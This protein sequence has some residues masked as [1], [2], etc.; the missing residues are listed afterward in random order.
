MD[1][2]GYI[3]IHLKDLKIRPYP[4]NDRQPEA[5]WGCQGR[6][7]RERCEREHRSAEGMKIKTWRDR[8]AMKMI[9]FMVQKSQG[10]PPFGCIKRYK[11]SVNNGINI[12]KHWI[13]Y[14]PQLVGR[15][16]EPSTV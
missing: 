14:Q 4:G 7:P 5:S 12:D 16:F 8:E 9:R 3:Q 2:M 15:I 10:Q 1:A 6:G 13:T 11:T